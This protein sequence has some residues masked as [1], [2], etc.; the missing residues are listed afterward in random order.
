L[1]YTHTTLAQAKVQL[2]NQLFDSEMS[3]WTTSE[4]GIYIAEAIR[5]WASAAL[6][7]RSRGLLSTVVGQRYY[8]IPSSVSDG[9]LTQTVTDLSLAQ[10]IEL[11]LVEPVTSGAW[12]GTEEF[13]VGQIQSAL[14]NRLNRFILEVGFRHSYISIEIGPELETVS[15]PDTTIETVRAEWIAGDGTVMP[16]WRT[17][18]LQSQRLY[19]SWVQANGIPITYSEADSSPLKLSLVPVPAEFSHVGVVTIS[20]HPSLDLTIAQALTIPDDLA[21]IVKWGA[22][23]DLLADREDTRAAYCEKRWTEGIELAKIYPSIL[24]ARVD[25]VPVATSTLMDLDSLIPNWPNTS[26]IPSTVA[27]VSYDLMALYPVPSSADAEITL[28]VVRKA[29]I[30]VDDADY[31]DVPR[32]YL[33]TILDYAQHLALFKVGG[34]DFEAS[35]PAYDQ[36]VKTA[37]LQNE[38]LLAQAPYFDA[39]R[40]QTRLED[41]RL[42]RRKE[43]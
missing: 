34:T 26:G 12:I 14:Q 33:S 11:H 23:A 21:W 20:S 3:F 16:L 31:I 10:E 41:E 18:G 8:A 1:G 38:R 29:P 4:L 22:L 19:P 35:L 40:G 17:D 32:E 39:L 2:A 24:L 9:L 43:S 27:M 6:A 7:F 5:I 25:D 15:L 13:S 28:D 37:S 30:P 42:P 36:M